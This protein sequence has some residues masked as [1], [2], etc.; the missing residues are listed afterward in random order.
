[1]V[2]RQAAN[3]FFVYGRVE[4][5]YAPETQLKILECFHSWLLRVFAER[6]VESLS[7]LDVLELRRLM[8]ERELSVARQY[9]VLT[10]LKVFLNFCRTVLKLHC[11]D[12][13]EIRLP[14]RVY[15][16]VEYLTDEE[17]H[18][19]LL[20]IPTHTFTGVRIRTLVEVLLS[21]GM[22]VSEA[23]SLNRDVL[24]SPN[25]EVE[26]RGKG[27]KWRTVFLSPRCLCWIRRLLEF[28]SD[29]HPAVFITTGR[30]P[31][32]LTRNDMSKLFRRLRQRSG[33]E[34][35]LTPHLLRHT[36]C[37]SLL[38]RGAD[39]TFIKELAGHQDIQTTARYYLGV[40][41]K[42]IRKVLERCQPFGWQDHSGGQ[43]AWHRKPERPNPGR[44]PGSAGAPAWQ[45]GDPVP[46]S[47]GTSFP[48]ARVPEFP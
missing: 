29:Q 21:T 5:M 4:R 18:R 40:D 42:A 25:G 14:R 9:N 39:I 22:R 48:D 1:M 11:L 17:I 41:N 46:G 13:A 2:F 47:S 19:L 12:P 43:E 30:T 27:G 45:P 3:L 7:V 6:D 38:H 23:L 26:I 16:K 24:E 33:V 35:H 10:I 36:F 44:T 34:K 8:T 20:T 32:R 31:R 15:R 37:T 28:R